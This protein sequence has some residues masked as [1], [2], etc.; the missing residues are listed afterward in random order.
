MSLLAQ[1][2]V[3]GKNNQ[4]WAAKYTNLMPAF[5]PI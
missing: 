5:S 3:L 1:I 4:L 2:P